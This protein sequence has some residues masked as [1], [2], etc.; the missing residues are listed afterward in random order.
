MVVSNRPG[1]NEAEFIQGLKDTFKPVEHLLADGDQFDYDRYRFFAAPNLNGGNEYVVFIQLTEDSPSVQMCD[2]IGET[3][4]WPEIAPLPHLG[5]LS[6][7]GTECFSNVENGKPYL[8][9]WLN[10]GECELV[11]EN[12]VRARMATE[13]YWKRGGSDPEKLWFT[14]MG[15]SGNDPHGAGVHCIKCSVVTQNQTGGG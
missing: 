5:M 2:E 14:G 7:D 6:L 11:D 8:Y 15:R 4:T 13:A 12:G 3:K 1:W 9:R 10:W